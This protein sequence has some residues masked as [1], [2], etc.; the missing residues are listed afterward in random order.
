ME[1][2]ILSTHSAFGI[3]V[4]VVHAILRGQAFIAG[5][6]NERREVATVLNASW[7]SKPLRPTTSELL[8][9]QKLKV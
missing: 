5:G 6:R 7:Y 8:S 2:S 3:Y 1:G 4:V 9:G